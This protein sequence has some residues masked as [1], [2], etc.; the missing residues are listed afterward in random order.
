MTDRQFTAEEKAWMEPAWES[1]WVEFKRI[2]SASTVEENACRWRVASA[3]VEGLLD[4]YGP[5]AGIAEE[6]TQT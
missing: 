6:G 2:G 5:S 1:A 3:A 4:K